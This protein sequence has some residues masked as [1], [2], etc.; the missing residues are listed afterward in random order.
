[1]LL[2]RIKPACQHLF[3]HPFLSSLI[4]SIQPA[5]RRHWKADHYSG[6][7]FLVNTSILLFLVPLEKNDVP[8]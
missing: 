1:D 2:Y 4:L 8:A 7:G 6:F 3:Q 5:F